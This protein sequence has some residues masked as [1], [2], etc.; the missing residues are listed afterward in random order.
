ME[1]NKNV[2]IEEETCT[3]GSFGKSYFLLMPHIN[4]FPR[5]VGTVSIL[6]YKVTKSRLR[7]PRAL[8]TEELVQY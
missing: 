7:K 5:G 6:F 8:E 3:N 1:V 4:F 2:F